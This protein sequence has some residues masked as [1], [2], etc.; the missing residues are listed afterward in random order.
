M[1]IIPVLVLQ[2]AVLLAYAAYGAA[3]GG[4]GRAASA[5][6]VAVGAAVVLHA[7]ALLWQL[8]P[9][10]RLGLGVV[11]SAFF[12][13]VVVFARPHF[14]FTRRLLAGLAA[15]ASALPL[16]LPAKAA[17]AAPGLHAFLAIAAYAACAAA[18]LHWLD[19]RHNER[20][21]RRQP[22]NAAAAPA[23]LQAEKNCFRS[24][25]VAFVLL[26]AVIA[27]GA[28][29]WLQEGGGRWFTH[30]NL[31][32]VLTWLALLVLLC[33]RRFYGWRGKTA[34]AWLAAAAVFLTLSYV[35][36]AFVLRVILE[37]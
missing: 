29:A 25:F 24:V 27:S 19:L 31:F 11:V 6:R 21:L 13:L 17:D 10:P 23:L 3:L 1:S 32:A 34:Q 26:C 36:S 30:K 15:C 28:H 20:L 2:A 37:R 22:Q 33:G 14:V 12:W 5:A 4:G 7:L 35:G 16:L 18:V 8:S 9:Q